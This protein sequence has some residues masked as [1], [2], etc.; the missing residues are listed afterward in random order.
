MQDIPIRVRHNALMA[1]NKDT[2]V[3]RPFREVLAF[4]RGDQLADI[5]PESS[6]GF[7]G[8]KAD[9]EARLLDHAT[10]V[11]DIQERLYA[12]SK[13]GGKRS[14]LLVIQGMDTSGKGGIMRHVVGSVDPQG[15][16]YTAFKAPTAEE[17]A[18]D[19]LWRIRNALPT[20]GLI[21][22]F[23]RSH[24]E[25]VL[26][27][28]VHGLVP[29]AEWEKRYALINAFEREVVSAGTTIIKCMLHISKDEQKVRLQERLDRPDKHYKYNPGDVTERERWDDYMTA[30]Q[31]L[32]SKCSTT[33]APW[34]VVPANKKWYA[35]MAV[36]QLLLEHLK[37][38]DPQWPKGDFDVEVEKQRLAAS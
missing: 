18:H 4:R 23:D 9:G 35:R 37:A 27:V 31:V 16:K 3:E 10:Q 26:I 11:G 6:P 8:S 19:F 21:G 15:V 38:M 12:E 32:L 2:E 14:V 1:K 36:Q 34:F 7:P 5:D 24:Y 30:Y 33:G 28:R 17:R 25:D 29:Q 13:G 20:P 22:V